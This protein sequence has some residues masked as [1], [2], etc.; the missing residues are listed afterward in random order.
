MGYEAEQLQET[1]VSQIEWHVLSPDLKSLVTEHRLVSL[2]LRTSM[3]SWTPT[4]PNILNI[5]WVVYI[6]FVFFF[7]I[8]HCSI[9][10]TKLTKG[11]KM[12]WK[13]IYC[14]LKYQNKILNLHSTQCCKFTLGKCSSCSVFVKPTVLQMIRA[15][16]LVLCIN[17]NIQLK[18]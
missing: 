18:R 16:H 13:A 14:E 1:E 3:N 5:L 9:H 6:V 4:I 7:Y 10:K 8:C 15:A 12:A 17:E 2:Y 11:L